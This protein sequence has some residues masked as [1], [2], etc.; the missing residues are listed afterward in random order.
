LAAKTALRQMGKNADLLPESID[1]LTRSHAYSIEKAV[2]LL[3]YQPRINLDQG[4][5]L[6]ADWLSKNGILN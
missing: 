5:E 4:M 6:T 3:G 1:F 2:Q